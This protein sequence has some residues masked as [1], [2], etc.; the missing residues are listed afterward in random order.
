MTPSPK[1]YANERKSKANI[2]ILCEASYLDRLFR[3][4]TSSLFFRCL[5]STNEI[6][7]KVLRLLIIASIVSCAVARV[8]GKWTDRNVLFESYL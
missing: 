5:S 4:T 7:M 1:P 6:K 2:C 8:V 3:L